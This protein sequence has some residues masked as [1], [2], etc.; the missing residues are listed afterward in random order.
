MDAGQRMAE[1]FTNPSQ[2][3]ER[4][5]Q[6][7]QLSA[8]GVTYNA[9]GLVFYVLI[10]ILDGV[11]NGFPDSDS[12]GLCADHVA[13]IRVFFEDGLVYYAE[14]DVDSGATEFKTGLELFT[15]A[16]DDCF[17]GYTTELATTDLTALFPYNMLI[18]MLFNAGFLF[19]DT[20]YILQIWNLEKDKDTALPYHY[21]F[22]AGDFALRLIY[23][24]G[25]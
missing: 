13:S 4:A 2:A 12:M 6:N 18:N 24:N 15:T 16:F 3:K 19:V 9:V 10:G 17:T 7:H 8:S 14:G 25:T 5:H 20:V 1:Y 23:S 22:F 11:L 21:A